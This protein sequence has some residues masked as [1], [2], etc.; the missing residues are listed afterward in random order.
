MVPS[1]NT[2]SITDPSNNSEVPIGQP[3]TVTVQ[4][5]D[6]LG[7]QLPRQVVDYSVT[8]ISGPVA[9][10]STLPTDASGQAT[11]TFTAPSTPGALG[12]NTSLASDAT[13]ISNIQLNVVPTFASLSPSRPAAWLRPPPAA[14]SR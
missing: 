6:S 12:V 4:A 11:F 7:A 13:A 8:G 9:S 2:I 5:F 3:V 1:G 14:R 10:G